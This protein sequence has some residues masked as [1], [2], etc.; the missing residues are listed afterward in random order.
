MA[1]A[2]YQDARLNWSPDHRPQRRSTDTNPGVPIV[3]YL[4]FIREHRPAA[5]AL[6]RN[7]VRF[8]ECGAQTR[9]KWP[10]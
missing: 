10:C 3:V 6:C 2:F 4:S 7:Q 8:I 9:S 1:F 5:R